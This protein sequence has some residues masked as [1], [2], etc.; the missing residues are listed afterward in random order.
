MERRRLKRHPSA[1]RAQTPSHADFVHFSWKSGI[2]PAENA[3]KRRAAPPL[4]ST[5]GPKER[6]E[7][8]SVDLPDS[9]SR[10]DKIKNKRNGA[11]G[12]P[13]RLFFNKEEKSEKE[14]NE[15]GKG[16]GGANS[17]EKLIRR[18]T[19]GR[20]TR[21]TASS[22]WRSWSPACRRPRGPWSCRQ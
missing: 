17:P 4:G 1:Q 11:Y 14:E 13:L 6:G 15:K 8:G 10:P 12:A 18:R 2:S 7:Q 5:A 21:G 16:G 20:S 3:E 9:G 22:R 19:A